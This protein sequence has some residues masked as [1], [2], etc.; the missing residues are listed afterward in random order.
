MAFS[1]IEDSL[2][3]YAMPYRPLD[4]VRP[5]GG[6]GGLSGSRF[7]RFR[8]EVGELVL[9]AWPHGMTR[10][11]LSAIQGW[12]IRIA[13][14]AGLP[15]PTPLLDLRGSRFH[16]REARLWDLSPWLPGEPDLRRP[17]SESHVGSA[18]EA[19]GKLHASLSPELVLGPSPGIAARLIE[20]E[21][22]ARSGFDRLESALGS[23]GDDPL[24]VEGRRWLVAARAASSRLLAGLRE[25]ADWRVP[26]QPCLRDARPDHFLFQGGRLT[27][28]LDMGAMDVETVAADLAR[29]CGDWLDEDGPLRVV[30][31]SAH[32]AGRGR[33]LDPIEERLLPLFESA[34]DLL[35]GGNWLRW[36]FLEGRQFHDAGAVPRGVAR[37]LERIAR[38]GGRGRV[39]GGPE[40]SFRAT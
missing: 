11:R 15:V 7:W 37:G 4:A 39:I 5:I 21:D 38:L 8:A 2:T 12:T 9:R 1:E 27:G 32:A 25:A 30:A 22:L 6:G 20:I 14:R 35:I 40:T 29:L 24:A 17:P 13:E 31:K 3:R 16:Q 10:A 19:L 34:A 28:L 23:A 33:A 36:H 18:F 26:L